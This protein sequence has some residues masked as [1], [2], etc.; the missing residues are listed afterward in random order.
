MI[1][2]PSLQ[3]N[4]GHVGEKV[5]P[6]SIFPVTDQKV[7]TG[8]HDRPLEGLL[9]ALAAGAKFRIGLQANF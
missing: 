4:A 5:R 8:N 3:A 7:P 2:H 6:L 9:D 1:S